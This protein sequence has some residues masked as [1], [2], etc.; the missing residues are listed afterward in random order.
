MSE[1]VS[2]VP[3]EHFNPQPRE[4]WSNP[5][6]W[7]QR[8]R[9]LDP[10][11]WTLAAERGDAGVWYV[12]RYEDAL[13]IRAHPCLSRKYRH[14][15]LAE[16]E[17]P[18][19]MKPY[20]DKLRHWMVE[21][22]AP[23]H[24]RLRSL[25][26]KHFTSRTVE[27]LRPKLEGLSNYL[28]DRVL[29]AG[30]MDVVGQFAYPMALLTIT[31][32]LGM[33]REDAALFKSWSLT[34]TA[35]ENRRPT[36]DLYQR[37]SDAVLEFDAYLKKAIAE[38]RKAPGDDVLSTLVMAR[39]DEQ[40]TDDEVIGTCMLMLFAGHETT[41]NILGNSVLTLLR[42]PEQLQL[43][44]AHPELMESAVEDLL[45]YESPVQS[46]SNGHASEDFEL[47]GKTIR[48]GQ[49]V[50]TVFGSANRD[51]EVFPDPDRLDITRQAN[52]HMAFGMGAHNCLGAPLAR[53]EMR[54][55]LET[56]LRRLP[57]LRLLSETANWKEGLML[58]GLDSL[59]VAF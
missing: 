32:M 39:N 29:A 54:V 2:Q 37:A 50:I 59:P 28:I 23:H 47:G 57:N 3:V 20:S 30:R 33:P 31:E 35:I 7:Y 43:L 8:Y 16:Q 15:R 9:S 45:R 4:V 56:L 41:V 6:P 11:H 27:R 18:P 48:K 5:Y 40:L 17:I 42:N 21:M 44:R 19:A 34:F 51:P 22:D 25:T 12:F 36:L 26:T 49:K 13:A 52:R 55:A 10:V 58:R 38:R 1:Q 14:D 53:L 46:V 24:T